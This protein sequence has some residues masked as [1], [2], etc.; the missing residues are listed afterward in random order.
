MRRQENGVALYIGVT[1]NVTLDALKFF[2]LDL[3]HRRRAPWLL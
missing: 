2:C 3:F 1:K